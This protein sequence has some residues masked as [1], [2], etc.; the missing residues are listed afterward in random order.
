MPEDEEND[1]ASRHQSFS[2]YQSMTV[3]PVSTREKEPKEI[4]TGN[5][6]Q[7]KDESHA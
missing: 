3:S 1:K 6:K 2:P 4:R 5:E 7:G